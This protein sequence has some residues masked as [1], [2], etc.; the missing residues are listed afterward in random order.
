MLLLHHIK[1]KQPHHN[2]VIIGD[3]TNKTGVGVVHKGSFNEQS[4]P[5]LHQHP[6]ILSSLDA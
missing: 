3:F 1:V 4:G 2:E 6:P 5:L